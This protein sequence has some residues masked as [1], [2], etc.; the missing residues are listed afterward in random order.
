MATDQLNHVVESAMLLSPE[1]LEIASQRI[2]SRKFSEKRGKIH[3]HQLQSC[4]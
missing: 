3:V 2:L 4:L 1:E